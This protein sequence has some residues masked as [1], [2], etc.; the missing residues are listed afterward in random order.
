MFN[1]LAAL[2]L[3]TLV[4]AAPAA[5]H[6]Y[7]TAYPSPYPSSYPSSYPSAYPS[8]PAPAYSPAPPYAQEPAY[9]R[10]V[11]QQVLSRADYDYDGGITLAEAHAFGRADFARQD[12]DRNG[13]LTR[14]ELRGPGH[15]LARGAGRGGVVTF[16]EFDANV[17][18]R[19]YELDLNRDAYLSNYELGRP[20][21]QRNG[22]VTWS[23]R[24]TL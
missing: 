13:V 5:A 16:A 20:A 23:W 17:R 21:P 22:G 19:F 4:T 3:A 9:S 6:A 18:Q 10:V 15:E 8:Y 14:R 11:Y 1:Q 24:W 7:D 2:G 12:V